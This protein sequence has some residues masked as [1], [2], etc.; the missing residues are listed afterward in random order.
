MRVRLGLFILFIGLLV[1]PFF[2][3]ATTEV[4]S[5]KTEIENLSKQINEKKDK[6]KELE[7]S[8]E[9]YKKRVNQKQ[10]EARSLKNQMSI[11]DNR[12]SQVQLEID[13]TQTNLDTINLKIETLNL[14]I[15]D[16]EKVI[17]RQKKIVAELIRT[18]QMN[19]HKTYLEIAAAYDNFSDFYN[20][21]QS[22]QTVDKELGRNVKALKA[23]RLDLENKQD[24]ATNEKF[25]YE[26]S[27]DKL[28]DQKKDLQ[29]NIFS[30]RELLITTK[31]SEAVYST[32]LTNLKKQYQQIEGEISFIERDV[33]KRLEQEKKIVESDNIGL[34]SW[35]VPG[36]YITAVFHDPEYPY[37]NIFEH[38]GID[39]RA[40]HGTPVT[41]TASGYVG[42]AKRCSKSSCYSYIM[43]IHNG[44][45][46]TL[47]GHLSGIIIS[48]DQYVNKGDVIGYSGGTPGTIGAGPFVTG[49]HLHFEVRK[50]GIPVNPAPY[51]GI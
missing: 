7:S 43:L 35:P 46:A 14:G 11:L 19:D 42:Q 4:A 26:E 12:I 17:E 13:K 6:I 48:E 22:L 18:I 15:Q 1:T 31:S 23:T 41:A 9:E 8:I 47:Y 39:I 21:V 51:L 16:K 38:T 34:L 10:L 37:R 3:F 30:K 25:A 29:E 44:G 2:V 28:Q 50:D 40:S 27:R 32:V 5:N 45:L 24:E 20:K 33:R 49:P 36:R